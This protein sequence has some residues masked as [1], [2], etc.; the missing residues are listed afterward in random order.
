MKGN[1]KTLLLVSVLSILVIISVI[2]FAIEEVSIALFCIL[3]SLFIAVLLHRNYSLNKSPESLYKG[4]VANILKTYDAIL[5]EIENL[6]DISEKKL[7]QTVSFKDLVNTEYE[8][9]KPVYYI[10]N[11]NAYDFILINKDD[12]YTYTIKISD[13]KMSIL[14]N[15]LVEKIREKKNPNTELDMLDSLDKTT[16]IKVDDNKEYLVSPVRSAEH[17]T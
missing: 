7:I 6:P 13:D 3:F 1:N 5:V 8:L 10:H 12:A 2:M 11:E 4:T 17:K 15:F 16:V 14:E 9:R